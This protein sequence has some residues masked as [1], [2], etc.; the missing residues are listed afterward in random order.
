MGAEQRCTAHFRGKVAAGEAHLETDYIQFR[1][2]AFRVRIE[3]QEMG[4]VSADD[5]SLTIDGPDGTLVLELGRLAR[6]WADK[7]LN[8]PSLLDK[9]GI[10]PHHRVALFGIDDKGLCEE[11]EQIAAAVTYNEIV[12]ETDVVLRYIDRLG[13][14]DNVADDRLHLSEVGVIWLVFEKGRPE[15]KAA[16]VIPAAKA[17]DL[18]DNRVTRFSDTLTALR[19]SIPKGSRK[20]ART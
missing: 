15:V 20:K 19:F 12:S 8:P 5:A 3:R 6:K 9:L 17:H 14:I 18:V 13:E 7:I 10:K 4:V 11:I 1:S 16:T 2:E